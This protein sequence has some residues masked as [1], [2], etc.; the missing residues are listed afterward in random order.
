MADTPELDRS[1][2]ERKKVEMLFAHLKTTPRFEHM[3]LRGLSGANDEFFM[4]AITR[5]L[6]RLVRL[7]TPTAPAPA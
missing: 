3:R 4:A 1:R 7:T 6:R 5:N 2:S